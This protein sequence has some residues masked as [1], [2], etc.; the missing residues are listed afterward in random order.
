MKN[1]FDELLRLD[2]TKGSVNIVFVNTNF[3]NGQGLSV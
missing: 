1:A 2:E 3:S